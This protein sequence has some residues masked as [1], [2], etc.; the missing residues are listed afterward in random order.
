MLG[1][2]IA[3]LPVLGSLPS[4]GRI[5]ILPIAEAPGGD[6]WVSQLIFTGYIVP[7][8]LVGLG[9]LVAIVAV[10]S[11]NLRKTRQAELEASLKHKM[12]DQGMSAD[13]IKKVLGAS[14][15]PSWAQCQQPKNHD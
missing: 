11:V 6:N 4:F 10:V 8:G 5:S 12:L 2:N 9:C 3:A 1:V 13:D 7:L 14:T 15:L